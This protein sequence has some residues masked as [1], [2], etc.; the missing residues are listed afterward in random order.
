MYAQNYC[1]LEHVNFPSEVVGED[2][3]INLTNK[4]LVILF[5]YLYLCTHIRINFS[6]D[7]SIKLLSQKVTLLI[8]F[9]FLQ[10]IK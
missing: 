6:D 4:K 7:H 8:N 10:Q 2:K 3:E 9:K 1:S 5:Y